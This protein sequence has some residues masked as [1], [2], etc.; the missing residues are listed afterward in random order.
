MFWYLKKE[1]RD[2]SPDISEV[3]IHYAWGPHGSPPDWGRFEQVRTLSTWAEKVEGRG[4]VSP[5]EGRGETKSVWAL[6][7][8]MRAKI[9]KIPEGM[10]NGQ[11][12]LHADSF[13]LHHYFEIHR[14]GSVSYSDMYTE[15]IVSW[16]VEYTDWTGAIIAVCAHWSI[17]DTDAMMYAPT[18]DPR[19]LEWYG[20]DN[21]FRSIRIY[22][23]VDLL[24]FAGERWRL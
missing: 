6:P 11:F 23:A 10:S 18:E 24:R 15:E 2:P 1:W 21:E 12:G 7:P 8:G 22:Q 3:K 17:G 20:H 4:R 5:H 16:E 13:L 9:I 19:F 14:N